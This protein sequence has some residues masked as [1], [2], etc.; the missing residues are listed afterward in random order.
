MDQAA[1]FDGLVFDLLSSFQNGVVTAEVDVSRCYILQALVIAL[2][3]VVVDE[4]TDFLLKI[5]G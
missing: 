1:C 2:M 4:V 3:I 5:T